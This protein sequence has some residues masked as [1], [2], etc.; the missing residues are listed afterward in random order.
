MRLFNVQGQIHHK[1]ENGNGEYVKETVTIT[2]P[3]SR[4]KPK[5]PKG[6]AYSAIVIFLVHM[7]I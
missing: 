5:A 7:Y 3:N 6:N 4:Q 1:I 2:R